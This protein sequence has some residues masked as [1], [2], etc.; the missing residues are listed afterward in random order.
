MTRPTVYIS[1]ATL[2]L[3]CFLPFIP[4]ILTSGLEFHLY[5]NLLAYICYVY[6]HDKAKYVLYY[7]GSQ[8]LRV[9]T[10]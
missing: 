5:F 6:L 1:L 10:H 4:I 8:P 9:M 7:S 2:F 3:F